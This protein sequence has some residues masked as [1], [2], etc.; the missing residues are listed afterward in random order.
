MFTE[1]EKSYHEFHHETEYARF[2]VL[3]SQASSRGFAFAL[4]SD[5]RTRG[6]VSVGA[7]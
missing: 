4:R 6:G 5:G 2:N 7:D 1:L 3:K